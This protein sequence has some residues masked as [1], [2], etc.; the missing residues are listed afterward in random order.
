MFQCLQLQALP[1]SV[2]TRTASVAALDDTRPSEQTALMRLLLPL[3]CCVFFGTAFIDAQ[4][5]PAPTAATLTG[6]VTGGKGQAFAAL[7]AQDLASSHFTEAEYFVSGTSQA[8]DK[9][10]AWGLDGKWAVTRAKRADYA[11]RILV[12]RPSDP[13]R[14][15]GALIV[16]VSSLRLT[17]VLDKRSPHARSTSKATQFSGRHRSGHV[18]DVGTGRGDGDSRTSDGRCCRHGGNHS[19]VQRPVE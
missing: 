15:N 4:Q 6:P 12:R 11:I 7:T 16:F 13:R 10:G 5:S 8:Y 19:V 9:A 14:F 1:F 3:F 18:G 17:R 2:G